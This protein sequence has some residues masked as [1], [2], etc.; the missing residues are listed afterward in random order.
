HVAEELLEQL[1]TFRADA[2]FQLV[3]YFLGRHRAIKGTCRLDIPP[4]D[5]RQAYD[6][7]EICL[8]VFRSKDRKYLLAVVTPVLFK[9][10]KKGGRQ[11]LHR[12]TALEQH[13]LQVSA[14]GDL[15]IFW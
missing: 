12:L 5:T 10:G 14:Y 15:G 1:A 8:R 7:L 11:R 4:D 3:H 6:A 2:L 13:R 9:V